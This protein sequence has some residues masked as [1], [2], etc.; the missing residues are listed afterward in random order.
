MYTVRVV[1]CVIGLLGLVSSGCNAY[2][3]SLVERID[4]SVQGGCN[5][6]S[7]TPPPRPTIADSSTNVPT[8]YF[9]MKDVLFDTSSQGPRGEVW[10]TTGF[11]LDGL[12]S[13]L[14]NPVYACNPPGTNPSLAVD[15]VGGVDN[16]FG[17]R[18]FTLVDLQYTLLIGNDPSPYAANLQEYSARVQEE[19]MAV[20][21]ARISGWNGEANDPHVRVD[22]SQSVYGAPGTGSQTT[23]PV[24][25]LGAW[26]PGTSRTTPPVLP[27]WD[28]DDWFWARQDSY[29][30]N[31]P[32]TPII[33][34]DTA[35][36]ANNQLVL[37]LPSRAELVFVGPTLGLKIV[38]TGGLAVG[39]ITGTGNAMML[40]HVLIGGRWSK[41]DLLLT[42]ASVNVCP[43]S[44]TYALINSSLDNI[45]DLR[46][47]ASSDGQGLPCDALS[48]G[49]ELTGYRAHFAGLV[50]GPS[51][52][53]PCNP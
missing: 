21:L 45:M 33:F 3:A 24:V 26:V 47:E 16:V 37:H 5:Q 30:A 36:I 46:S 43:G 10:Q 12:C 34:D 4:G 44:Q 19:G 14:A 23:P 52:P 13:T 53:T 32:S 40:E 35:Y 25:N 31:D 29:I 38:L 42:S 11:N 17:P 7:A 8:I 28:G 49:A 39:T 6:G 51:L 18:L 15:G 22:I 1:A 41:T 27:A 9:A 50:P 48:F 20:L 2:D